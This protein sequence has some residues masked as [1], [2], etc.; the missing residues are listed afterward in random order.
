MI[1]DYRFRRK[2][3]A[4]YIKLL[5]KRIGKSKAQIADALHI[6]VRAI[7][8][9]MQSDDEAAKISYTTQICLELL[10][11]STKKERL[12]KIRDFLD[13]KPNVRYDNNKKEWLITKYGEDI[14]LGESPEQALGSLTDMANLDAKILAGEV[15]LEL[16]EYNEYD[17]KGISYPSY[18]WE[19]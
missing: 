4:A 18:Q 8:R 14:C 13:K 5:I 12:A 10:A 15:G 19:I 3:T 11:E 6:T 17:N 7:D 2:P 16:V 1:A 9:W